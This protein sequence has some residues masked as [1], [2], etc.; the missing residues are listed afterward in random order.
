[1]E[2][3]FWSLYRVAFKAP[4]LQNLLMCR[5]I[6][7]S[8]LLELALASASATCMMKANTG[9]KEDT[10]VHKETLIMLVAGY[11]L[12]NNAKII[13]QYFLSER[14]TEDRI[15]INEKILAF[16][17]VTFE[18]AS[19]RWREE[20]RYEIQ[21]AFE[22][23]N[24]AYNNV[25]DTLLDFISSTLMSVYIVAFISTIS[26]FAGFMILLDYYIMIWHTVPINSQFT[27]S[28]EK[29]QD[30]QFK[31][32][33][34]E[35]ASAFILE[36]DRHTNPMRQV[37]VDP[38]KIQQG[39]T[40]LWNKYGQIRMYGKLACLVSAGL[41]LMIIAKCIYESDYV[42]AGILLI[43][44]GQ[45]YGARDCYVFRLEGMESNMQSWLKDTFTMLNEIK[46][47]AMAQ[48]ITLLQRKP[49]KLVINQL[50]Y[51]VSEPIKPERKDDD[52]D[53]DKKQPSSSAELLQLRPNPVSFF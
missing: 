36:N 52:E 18:N 6:I 26:T 44:R 5:Y 53:D 16:V 8:F 41:Y 50:N 12:L 3:T 28:F 48:V 27:K 45:I 24:N 31:K 32:I 25:S 1:M 4:F 46:P 34:Q 29:Q 7:I 19:H 20:H 13:N 21:R 49:A 37:P 38:L 11:I 40:R 43:N 9:L 15:N 10:K 23:V 22:T 35:M 30:K 33:R 39:L 2:H 14:V 17:K 42:L 51:T 47:V